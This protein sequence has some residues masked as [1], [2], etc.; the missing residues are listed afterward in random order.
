MLPLPLAAPL[1]L[2]VIWRARLAGRRA[3]GALGLW[4]L[5]LLCAPV[6]A[7]ALDGAPAEGQPLAQMAQLAPD[8][9]WQPVQLPRRWATGEADRV[10][11]RT[12]FELP[13]PDGQPWALQFFRLPPDH[14]LRINGQRVSG[15]AVRAGPARRF[16]LRSRW[17]VLPSAVLRPGRNV[18]E[19]EFALNHH[20]GGVSAPVLGRADALWPAYRLQVQ[21]TESLPYTLNGAA[22]GLALFSLL[23]WWL[24]RSERVLGFFGALWLLISLRNMGYYIDGGGLQSALADYLLFLA[25]CLSAALLVGFATALTPLWRERL[26]MRHLLSALCALAA[27]GGLA[28]WHDAM[29]LAWR[30]VYPVLMAV[31]VASCWLLWQAARQAPVRGRRWVLVGLL[32]TLAAVLHDYLFAVGMFAITD[33][34]WVPFLA[35]LLMAAA[36]RA[37]LVRFVQALDSAE[38]H[39]ADLERRVAERTR[40]LQTA[41][42]AKTRFIAA[43]SHD[44]RQPVASIGL[45][46]GLLR[47]QLSGSSSLAVLQRLGESVQALEN[48][49]KGLL[50]LSRFDAGSLRV[51]LQRVPLR[52]VF[53][54]VASH[55]REQAAGKGL[56]LRLRDGGL[57]VHTDPVLLEQI[58]R[59]L[60]NNALRYT[61]HGGVLL[62]ARRRGSEVLLQV[63]DTGRGIPADRQEQ[64]FDEFVQLDNPARERS[65][66]LGLGLSLVRRAAEVLQTPLRLWSQPGRG[67]C[68]TLRL[69]LVEQA[70]QAAAPRAA[71]ASMGLAGQLVLVVEDDEALRESLR[72][73]LERWGARVQAYA[74]LHP[75]ARAIAQG[76][77]AQPPQLL[78]TDH[79]LPDGG[80]AD[81]VALVAGQ[82]LGVPTLVVTGDTAAS[83]LAQLDAQGWPV[84][85]K[86]F[87]AD[88]LFAAMSAA[89]RQRR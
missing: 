26:T 24:R 29:P 54:A 57:V 68:F 67:S 9:R 22:A 40:A 2:W 64:V 11:L 42:A 10:Q 74:G 65:R 45:L 61:D 12:S 70:H 80:S 39:G 41:N 32:L 52:Q 85:H 28:A 82:H 25:Q 75:L 13:V 1:C 20:S 56:Q 55:E 4:L 15:Q 37:L 49:L 88:E 71:A 14:D 30:L 38:R 63:R 23:V 46:A 31:A 78:L 21:L 35:P 83:D 59:N 19:L 51:R 87:G 7:W 44:L 58:V 48:L 16:S 66:G 60:V 5:L 73:R 6:G 18:L 77:L 86:P 27:L 89:M 81:V 47:E 53:L 79:R 8:G 50:D 62:S 33:V 76:A 17:I 34:Y 72:L 3:L 69:P 84:L 43:A 36:S